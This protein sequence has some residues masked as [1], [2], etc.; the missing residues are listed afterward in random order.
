MVNATD[1]PTLIYINEP[2]VNQQTELLEE[3]EVEHLVKEY[4]STDETTTGGKLDV[5]KILQLQREKTT[6]STES[7][8]K[9]IR[10]TSRG[11]FAI[12]H[13]LLEEDDA[14]QD[15]TGIDRPL[16]DSFGDGGYM[17]ATG[18]IRRNPFGRF[19]YLGEEYDLYE[20]E[21]IGDDEQT[22]VQVKEAAKYYEM[23]MKN[24]DGSFIFKLN[25]DYF[26]GLEPDF[27]DE[28]REYTI[29]GEIRH[30]YDHDEK[31]HYLNILND[32]PSGRSHQE[33][34][35]RRRGMKR[36]AQGMDE[37]D[38]YM[39]YPDIEIDPIAIYR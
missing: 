26:Q 4:G 15:L 13:G 5:Y 23:P 36:L 18:S 25:D 32:A 11:N 7:S 16:R 6:G 28:Y 24:L 8:T 37:S 39:S 1:L 38:L 20:T 10:R 30:A 2:L 14:L 17:T 12:Y 9:K 33:R 35:E 27:P 3:G 31:N 22:M 34:T 21:E 19:D 29:V